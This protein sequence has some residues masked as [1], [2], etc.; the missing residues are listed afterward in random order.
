MK[1]VHSSIS[2]RGFSEEIIHRQVRRDM[3]TNRRWEV[4]ATHRLEGA[5]EENDPQNPVTSNPG[6]RLPNKN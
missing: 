5:E 4:I 1:T 3:R 6:R 2:V